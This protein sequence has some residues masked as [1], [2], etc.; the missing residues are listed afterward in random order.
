[1]AEMLKNLIEC[2]VYDVR[3][4]LVQPGLYEEERGHVCSGE[5]LMSDV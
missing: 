5:G 3:F 4:V 1:M 2:L